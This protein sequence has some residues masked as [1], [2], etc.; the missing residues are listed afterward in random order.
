MTKLNQ[1]LLALVKN[2][3]LIMIGK[4][5]YKFA[6]NL[7]S[8]NR[9]ITGEGVRQ[10]LWRISKHLQTLEIKSVASC[11]KVFDWTGPKE[12]SV[13]EAYIITPSSEKICDFSKNNLHLVG[14]SIP[15]E[16]EVSFNELKKNLYT[17]PDQPNAIPY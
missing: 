12:W 6:Q 17:L 5:I 13:E 7:W 3:N 11:T 8:L 14:Y 1:Y 4:N 2:F 10:T 15:F 9:S 16:D